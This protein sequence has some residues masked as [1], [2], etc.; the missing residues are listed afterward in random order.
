MKIDYKEIGLKVGLEIHQMLNTR[1]KLFCACPTVLRTDEPHFFF[2]RRLRPTRSELGEMDP[3]ALFEFKKGVSYRY[4]G[5]EDGIC[6][7]EMDEEPPHDL[8]REALEIALII[9]LMLKSM[10]VDELHVMRKIVIDGSNTT[11]F[12][13]TALLAIGGEIN[14]AGKNVPIQTICLEE[15]AA[16]KIGED[17]KVRQVV[18]RLDRMS[19]PLIEIATAPVINTP[20]EAEKVAFKIG[21]LLRISG[22]V[23]RGLGTIRQDL[24]VSIRNGARIEIKGVQELGLISK[25]VEYEVLR[26]LKLLEIK[27]EL[28]NR[29]IRREMIKDDFVDVTEIFAE[30]KS[31]IARRIIRKGGRAL[32]VKLPGFKGLIGMEIQPG[33][34]LG[35]E[36]ADRARYWA[37]IGGIFHS[38]ELPSYGITLEEV[39]KVK[40]VLKCD[41]DDA[42]VLVFEEWKKAVK[43][44]NAV[45]ERARDV[46]EGVPEE[47]RGANPDGTTRFLRPMPGKARMYPETD[48]KPIRIS[49]GYIEK[50]KRMLPEPPEAKY[51]KMVKVYR[52]SVRITV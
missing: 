32:A 23:K 34:R 7:V 39:N 44:L 52:L 6:L 13:R 19:I 47:T 51:E 33:R 43:A 22:R 27:K 12:Q 38:D 31:K 50:L 4:E 11:G 28:E 9:S 16:R 15:D 42:F 41:K 20:E 1:S 2:L 26:Q 37:E 10:P 21:Q 45:I 40:E 14:V 5:Y 35:T 25:I 30:T 49:E 18:Y 3:A 8:N 48:I 46:L 29:G 36:F 17:K 24:N